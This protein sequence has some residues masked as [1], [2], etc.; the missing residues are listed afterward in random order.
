MRVFLL[1]LCL[2]LFSAAALA[3]PAADKK[4]SQDAAAASD[5]FVGSETCATCHDE[6]AQKFASNKHAKL[7]EEHLTKGAGCESCHGPGKAHV[8]GG[9]DT[10]KI[11]NPAKASAK[12]VD[13]KCLTCHAGAHPNFERSPHAKANVGCT[14]CHSVHAGN[15]EDHLLKASQPQLCFQCHSDVK[16]QFN[17]PFHHRVNEGA[18]SC[19]DCHDVH[20]S[21][22]P[23]NLK[24]T[25]DQNE[26]CTKCH[27][28]KRGPFVYEH[29]AVKGEG[30]LSCHTP[31]GSQNA[32]LLNTPSI[33][34][35]CAQCHSLVA[36]NKV[37]N[38]TLLS[39][40]SDVTPCIDCHTMVHG[41]NLDQ[42]L[43][44]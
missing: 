8:D 24:S 9:G 3:A 36:T 39:Q 35:L 42:F 33:N 29:A 5:Q 31:H 2:G 32:R 21:F 38:S 19:N 23:N 13:A 20:G 17:M 14:G 11:F 27:M 30:C 41:S 44:R 22:G 10:T 40:S 7:A 1:M 16:P 15:T 26:V 4:T 28:E 37:H 18:V 43:K 34:V 25:A 12:D 6:V